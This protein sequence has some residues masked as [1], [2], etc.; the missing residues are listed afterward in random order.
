M[1]NK[2]YLN[3]KPISG[4]DLKGPNGESIREKINCN[5]FCDGNQEIDI[6]VDCDNGILRIKRV[7]YSDDTKYEFEING[8][9]RCS[10]N[11][12]GDWIP[13]FIFSSNYGNGQKI[14]MARIDSSHYGKTRNIAW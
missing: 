10:E 8:I 12:N 14:S 2:W 7:G 3:G 5:H 11:R 1:Y 4:S 9:N 13:H 6:F